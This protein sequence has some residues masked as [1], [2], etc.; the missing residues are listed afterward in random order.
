[1]P[2]RHAMRPQCPF[3]RR[4]N[5]RP[6]AALSRAARGVRH[7]SGT[8]LYVTAAQNHRARRTAEPADMSGRGAVAE[9]VHASSVQRFRI[10]AQD[11]TPFEDSATFWRTMAQLATILMAAIMFGA[12]LYIARPLLMPLICAL[13][14]ALTIGPLTGYAV[15]RGLPAFVP[16]GIIVV[17]IATVLYLT[18]M[19]LSD[20]VSDLIARSGEIGATIR[21]KFRFMDRPLNALKELQSAISGPST[22]SVDVSKP[23]DLIGSVLGTVT[24]A[25]LQ[26]VLFFATL[27]FFVLGRNAMR[28]YIVNIFDT[29]DGRLRALKIFNDTERSLNAYLLTVTSINAGVGIVAA[30]VT[31]LLGFPAPLLWVALAFAL[32]YIPYVGPGIMHATLFLIGLLTFDTLLPALIAPAL[33]M[34]FTFIEGHFLVPTIIGRQFLMH[35]LGVFLSLA[36]WAWLWGPIG[37]FL[38]T[39]I[40]IMAVVA[41]DHLYPRNKGTLP[42]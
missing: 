6:V 15:R 37:A 41:A 21:E 26:F 36:F 28:Q 12:L 23:T 20:P 35:P 30:L 18:I 2:I 33:F 16:A 34:T 22:L 9:P 29:R 24:P 13:I 39:P 8:D 3:L 19:L 1:V 14:V 4:W 5:R 17:I 40:L 11:P 7:N 31:W 42:E 27:F 10:G 25:M 38:A 32:N